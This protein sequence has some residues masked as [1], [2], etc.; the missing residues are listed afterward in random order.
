MPRTLTVV[1]TI[2]DDCDNLTLARTLQDAA[3]ILK[4]QGDVAI[5]EQFRRLEAHTVL[6]PRKKDQRLPVA[7]YSLKIATE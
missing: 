6:H 1:V 5:F 3:D 4:G 2:P 7:P